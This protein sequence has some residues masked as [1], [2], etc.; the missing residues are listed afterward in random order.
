MIIRNG[1]QWLSP[2]KRTWGKNND[3]YSSEYDTVGR[4]SGTFGRLCDPFE[5][6]AE[7]DFH[8]PAVTVLYLG[9]GRISAGDGSRALE[10]I[11]EEKYDLVF[12][13]HLMPVMDGVE[14]VKAPRALDGGYYKNLPVIALTG[15]TAKEQREEYIRSGMSDYLSKPID[16]EDICRKIRIWIPDKCVEAVSDG[17]E[18]R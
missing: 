6:G 8:G 4:D 3:A 12:M 10:R 17:A 11:K 2:L 5:E 16:M 9:Y 7:P 14:A 1:I 18:M 15:N 13:D